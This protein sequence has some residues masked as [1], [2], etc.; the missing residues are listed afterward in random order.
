MVGEMRFPFVEI[1][2]FQY[3]ANETTHKQQ[4]WR[5]PDSN[6]IL[7]KLSDEESAVQR[8]PAGLILG[9]VQVFHACLQSIGLNCSLHIPNPAQE[10]VWRKRKRYGNKR[11][12]PCV[13]TPNE[14]HCEND[15][16]NANDAGMKHD[17]NNKYYFLN[18]FNFT[19]LG[20][21]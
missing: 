3:V 18:E 2:P 20:L 4:E 9:R 16:F 5:S 19:Y 10:S 17:D 21:Q 13:N 8:L 6:C 1:F 7:L 14:E 12:G 15:S 11:R